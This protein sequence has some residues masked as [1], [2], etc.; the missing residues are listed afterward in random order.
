LTAPRGRATLA[1]MRVLATAVALALVA[2]AAA[3]ADPATP[4]RPARIDYFAKQPQ[5][6]ARVVK[7]QTE[8]TPGQTAILLGLFGASAAAGGLGLYFHLESRDAAEEVGS[9][10]SRPAATWT[11]AR[12]AT[13][14]DAHVAGTR[15]I[16]GYAAGGVL[17][18]AALGYA[19]VTRSRE[20][21]VVLVPVERGA[22]VSTGWRFW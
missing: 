20:R 4:D 11:P 1:P 14:D 22:V 3:A 19:W 8:R 2:P 6:R 12:Q 7:R 17:L 10:R 5:V 16:T 13:Y 18:G 9:V 15:A 21:E